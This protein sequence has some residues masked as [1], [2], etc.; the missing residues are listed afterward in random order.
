[1]V[2]HQAALRLDP[3]ADAYFL[4]VGRDRNLS[5]ELLQWKVRAALRAPKGIN[6]KSA[7]EAIDAMSEQ[8]QAEST[9]TYWRARGLLATGRG[10][11][12]RAEALKLLQGIASPKGFYE[13]LALEELGQKVTIPARPAPLTEE[14]TKAARQDPGLNRALYAIAIGL[15]SEG[16]REWNYTTNMHKAGGLGDRELLAAAQYACEREV[17]DRCINTSERTK[18][19]FDSEQRYPMPFR[20]AVVKRSGEIGLDPGTCTG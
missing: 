17:W 19:E 11:H 12:Q 13:Q 10:E 16:T 8:A 14:E 1:V 7:L 5:D 2:G 6:W 9:W 3:N 20:D 18:G 15:R 4:R